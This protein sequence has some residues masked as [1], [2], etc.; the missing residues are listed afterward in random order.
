[1]CPIVTPDFSEDR[2]NEPGSYICRIVGSEMKTAK[3]SGKAYLSWRL[4]TKDGRTVFYN[5][6]IMGKGAERFK[7]LVHMAGDESYKGGAYD[8]D[9]LIDRFV[10]MDLSVNDRGYF[11]VNGVYKADPS[12]IP[13]PPTNPIIMDADQQDDIPF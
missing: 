8:S 2:P 11:E 10:S 1:M 4:V 7:T 13:P 12:Q 3:S 6:P 5:T 9:R